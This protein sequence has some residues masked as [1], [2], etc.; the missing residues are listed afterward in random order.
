MKANE[1]V[2]LWLLAAAA[3]VYILQVHFSQSEPA[4]TTLDPYRSQ[5]LG[6]AGIDPF[7]MTGYTLQQMAAGTGL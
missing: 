1:Q 5:L 7:D 4:D 3:L 2:V 6:A